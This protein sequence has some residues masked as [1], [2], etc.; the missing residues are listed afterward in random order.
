MKIIIFL[1][2]GKSMCDFII[3]PKFFQINNSNN[4][5]YVRYI[6]L[7]LADSNSKEK[8]AIIKDIDTD[9]RLYKKVVE[10][11]KWQN[12][13]DSV[14]KSIENNDKIYEKIKGI[15]LENSQKR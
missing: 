15:V 9:T 12:E 8:S 4:F 11:W 3:D 5:E 13:K 1:D 14:I 7:H 2:L 10:L 6:P